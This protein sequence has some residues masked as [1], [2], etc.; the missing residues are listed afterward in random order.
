MRR[1]NPYFAG[2]DIRFGEEHTERFVRVYDAN[3]NKIGAIKRQADKPNWVWV[4]TNDY[5]EL[6][7]F[8]VL[9]ADLTT[10]QQIVHKM[11][12]IEV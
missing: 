7:P 1:E 3:G 12:T 5:R 10:A 6:F 8:R 4:S 11:L 2:D 9:A